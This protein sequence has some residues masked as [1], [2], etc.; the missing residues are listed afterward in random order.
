MR[1]RIIHEPKG[2]V[3][4]MSLRYYREGEAYEVSTR[5][6][7]YLVADGYAAI[8]MRRRQRSNRIRS[9]ER[10]HSPARG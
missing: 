1:V 10:R 2:T 7:E 6:A 9:N 3:D 8:E 5:L 4:G